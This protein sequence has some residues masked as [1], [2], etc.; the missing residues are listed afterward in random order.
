ML[1]G[2]RAFVINGDT[3]LDVNLSEMNAYHQDLKAW[4]T[5]AVAKVA[6]AGRFATLRLDSKGRVTLF[7]EKSAS[8]TDESC[9]RS[10]PQ[11]NG[12]VYLF[13]KKLLSR[14]PARRQV[15]LEKEVFPGLLQEK[16]LFGFVTDGFFLDIGVPDDFRRAQSELPKRFRI[17]DS[18]ESTSTD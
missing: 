7:M 6:D 15:S 14:I 1:G 11:I 10:R 12:G 8:G 5:L 13:E 3:F 9:S 17:G 2:K 4:A 16:R 18:H